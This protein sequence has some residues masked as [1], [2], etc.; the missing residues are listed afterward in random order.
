MKNK[1]K[2]SLA[3]LVVTFYACSTYKSKPSVNDARRMTNVTSEY[4]YNIIPKLNISKNQIMQ[5][6]CVSDVT[7]IKC[8]NKLMKY[9]T[10]FFFGY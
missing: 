5:I 8:Y 3:L 1:L 2:I 7:I 10:V 9:K 6:C 4:F